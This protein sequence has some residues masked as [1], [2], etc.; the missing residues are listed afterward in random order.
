MFVLVGRSATTLAD[1]GCCAG[2][3][4]AEGGASMSASAA[5]AA[6]VEAAM[7]T[8]REQLPDNRLVVV[9]DQNPDTLQCFSFHGTSTS[10]RVP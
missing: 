10:T 1:S 6:V 9:G 5:E 7:A 3:A 4:P 8:I 2:E